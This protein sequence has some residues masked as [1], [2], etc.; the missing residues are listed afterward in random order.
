MALLGAVALLTATE[1]ALRLRYR[2]RVLPSVIAE[3]GRVTIVALGDSIT[4]GAPGDRAAAWPS[5]LADHLAAADP[6]I[7]WRIVNA[8]VSGDTAPLGYARFERDVAAAGPR[9]VI[10]AFGLND[11]YPAR[12]GMDR[13]FEAWTPRGLGR[14]YLWRAIQVR[15]TRW[16][17]R[18]G[19][20]PLP[21]AEEGSLPIPRT[22]LAG[23]AEALD[24][25]VAR[26]R[27]IGAEPILLTMTPLAEAA[28]EGVPARA[29]TYP[30]Y[31]RI[32]R[33]R[34][35]AHRAALIELAAGAPPDAF[36]P[37]GFHLAAAGQAWVAG[38]IF[39]QGEQA[40]L[41]TNRES[42]SF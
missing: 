33:A 35:A 9:L 19:L 16:A 32:I 27:D 28:V 21:L 20:L 39:R 25:L 37:D 36:E 15:R 22:T 13:W 4:A 6:R 26:T 10:I 23:F 14:S 11:C 1:L 2:R 5:L 29:A 34:A 30:V 38:Q 24:A 31:N 7:A 3:P 17:R 41:W 42:L 12:H 8:G 40:G 18:L